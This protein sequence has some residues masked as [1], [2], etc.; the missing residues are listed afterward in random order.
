MLMITE[1]LLLIFLDSGTEGFGREALKDYA[2]L[3]SQNKVVT[4]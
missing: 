4:C 3:V 1:F 2:D